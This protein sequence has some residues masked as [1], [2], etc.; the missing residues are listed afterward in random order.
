MQIFK[1][2]SPI[3]DIITNDAMESFHS[4]LR[5]Y[6]PSKHPKLESLSRTLYEEGE[7]ALTNFT[8][9]LRKNVKAERI[10]KTRPSS[11]MIEEEFLE[12][13]KEKGVKYDIYHS[14]LKKII[15]PPTFDLDCLYRSQ[16]KYIKN[17]KQPNDIFKRK[18]IAYL[19][20][21]VK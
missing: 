12:I 6:F 18:R 3:D 16:D 4:R 2:I 5:S 8:E 21:I 20:E 19:R 13:I 7:K 10:K 17:P 15:E 14:Q 9:N 11:M 1:K